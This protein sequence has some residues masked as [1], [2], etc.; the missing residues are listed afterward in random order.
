M[1]EDDQRYYETLYGLYPDDW[2]ITYGTFSNHHYLLERDYIDTGCSTTDSSAASVTHMFIYPHYFKSVYFVEGVIIGQ[3][4]VGS[5]GATSSC[6]SYRVS[7]CKMSSS[8]DDEE[9]VSTGWVTVNDTLAWDS[10]LGVGDEVVYP[11]WIDCWQEKKIEDTERLYVKIEVT[12]DNHCIL[13]FANSGNT[14]DLK[15]EIPMRG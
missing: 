5:S 14:T 3:I 13:F 10:G 4:T 2:S 7:L 6:T 1:A 12:C 11:F 9:L 15:I 8:N